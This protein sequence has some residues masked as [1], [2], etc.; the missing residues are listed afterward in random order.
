MGA[1]GKE[2]KGKRGDEG[3]SDGGGNKGKE[4]KAASAAASF[5]SISPRG[6]QSPL[7]R[8]TSLPNQLFIPLHQCFGVSDDLQD[9]QFDDLCW[10]GN[11]P[12]RDCAILLCQLLLSAAL[13]SVPDDV[14]CLWLQLPVL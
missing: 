13:D 1:R 9:N 3:L 10:D 11:P 7:I 5:F 2:R 14:Y 8:V 6:N 12:F 4:T